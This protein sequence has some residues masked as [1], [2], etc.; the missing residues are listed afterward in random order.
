MAIRDPRRYHGRSMREM[1]AGD[2]EADHSR[3][4]SSELFWDLQRRYAVTSAGHASLQE[5]HR[6]L[7]E[8]LWEREQELAHLPALEEAGLESARLDA[9]LRL[10]Y[11]SRSWRYTRPCRW[12]GRLVRSVWAVARR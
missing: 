4:P 7:L 8:R 9:E 10:I 6:E 2:P 3:A 12:A 5:R 11:G 1:D